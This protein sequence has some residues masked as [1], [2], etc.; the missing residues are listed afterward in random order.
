MMARSLEAH[1]RLCE[2]RYGEINRRL[3]S[4]EQHIDDINKSISAFKDFF[5]QTSIKIGVGAI[6]ALFSAVYVIKI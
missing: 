4:I 1:E 3:D 5:I 2:Q 6:V